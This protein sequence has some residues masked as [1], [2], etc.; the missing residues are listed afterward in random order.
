M[1]DKKSPVPIYFQIE[2]EIKRRI[3]EGELRQGDPIP[4]ERE[5][6]E[7]YDVSRMTVRQAI[8]NL[9]NDGY[10]YR[11]KGRGT[12]VANEKIEQTLQGLTSFT[13]EMH[14]RG[15]KPANKLLGFEI[16]PASAGIAAQ[17][18]V[19]EHT[20]VCEIRRVRLADDKPMAYERTYLP[21]NLVKGLTESHVR[22]S[23]YD[24]IEEQ[25]ELEID[26]AMQIIESSIAKEYESELLDIAV[27]SSVMIIER[28]TFLKDNTPLEIVKSTYRAD[29]YKFVTK[30]YR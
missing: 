12:F 16:I 6:T 29:R 26:H 19:K 24:Y 28:H 20:P 27:G 7:K 8:T 3:E 18:K 22:Q 10:L 1:I 5:Y 2:E 17:L 11:Q 15:M 9:V 30:I 13:E 14:A 25:L 4:S 23:L 21:A